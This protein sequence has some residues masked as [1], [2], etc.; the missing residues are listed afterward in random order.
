MEVQVSLTVAFSSSVYIYRLIN[1]LI[2]IYNSLIRTF[3]FNHLEDLQLTNYGNR[4]NQS[5]KKSNMQVI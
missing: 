1:K 2:H 3:T 4:S 5:Q